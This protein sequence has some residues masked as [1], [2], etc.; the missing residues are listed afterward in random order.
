MYCVI[1]HPWVFLHLLL[2]LALLWTNLVRCPLC[3]SHNC[4][5]WMTI[6]Y[7]WEKTGVRNTETFGSSNLTVIRIYSIIA[8]SFLKRISEDIGEGEGFVEIDG[9][10][11]TVGSCVGWIDDDGLF[12][13]TSW[14]CANGIDNKRTR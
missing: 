8:L 7:L 5:N 14:L 2:D 12:V 10:N 1:I 4:T 9:T 13:G 6:N 3:Q 11:D